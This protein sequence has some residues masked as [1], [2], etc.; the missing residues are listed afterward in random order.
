MPVQNLNVNEFQGFV[1]I[2]VMNLQC[3]KIV[4]ADDISKPEIH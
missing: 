2:R 4:R 1:K 3:G